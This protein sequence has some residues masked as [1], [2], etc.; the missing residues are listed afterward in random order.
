VL[1]GEYVN[2]C[3]F[4]NKIFNT[5]YYFRKQWYHTHLSKTKQNRIENKRLSPPPPPPATSLC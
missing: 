2:F 1:G 3:K 4:I 5:N